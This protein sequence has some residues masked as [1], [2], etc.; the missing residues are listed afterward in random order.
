[1]QRALPGTV[2]GVRVRGAAVGA[3]QPLRHGQLAA[4]HR[5]VQRCGPPLV[6]RV[7]ACAARQQHLH[8]GNLAVARGLVEGGDAP[9]V[10]LADVGAPRQQPPGDLL[11]ARGGGEVQRRRGVPV[12]GVHVG[13][14]LDQHRGQGR[15][16]LV[17]QSSCVQRSFTKK[18]SASIDDDLVPEDEP[19]GCLQHVPLDGVE[20][21]AGLR[22]ARGAA[23]PAAPARGLGEPGAGRG[24]LRLRLRRG[25]GRRGLRAGSL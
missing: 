3:Q 22:G 21:R 13:A 11:V 10:L 20:Q 6:E 5:P 2:R 15:V 9:A 19:L 18:T 8:K 1:M 7:G 25:E 16:L 17:P 12:L 4:H 14:A 24:R 23:G